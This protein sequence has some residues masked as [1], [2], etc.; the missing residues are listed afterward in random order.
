MTASALQRA[1]NEETREIA[2]RT[3]EV[4]FIPSRHF[5]E[6]YRDTFG[7]LGALYRKGRVHLAGVLVRAPCPDRWFLEVEGLG[8][9]VLHRSTDALIGLT[10][11]PL[12][13]EVGRGEVA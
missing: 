10:L 12:A 5:R 7:N 8:R 11:I 9:V 3:T 1:K 2:T 6:K 4:D 13:P